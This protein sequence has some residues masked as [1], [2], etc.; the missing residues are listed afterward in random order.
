MKMRSIICMLGT[1]II[2]AVPTL[3]T[4]MTGREAAEALAAQCDDFYVKGGLYSRR[5]TDEEFWIMME[6][7]INK[8]FRQGDSCDLG[9]CTYWTWDDAPDLREYEVPLEKLERLVY[10][11]DYVD[12]WCK[13][14][15]PL[16]V[17]DG[18]DRDTAI[19]T[20]YDWI[21]AFATYDYDALTDDVLLSNE[22]SA[23][24]LLTTGKGVCASYSKLFRGMVEVVPF[25]IETGGVD[26]QSGTEYIKVAL[27]DKRSSDGASGHEWNAI[28]SSD[29]TWYCYDVTAADTS[30]N[31]N[32]YYKITTDMLF[33]E[34]PIA[35]EQPS[36]WRWFY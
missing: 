25:N 17:S 30:N 27:V 26:W 16:I 20:I 22:Q 33:E 15:V 31:A 6:A 29:G 19:R 5:M 3:A 34:Q 12:G 35:S 7:A 4:P 28:Q 21:I 14:N 24:S 10:E 23:Y 13:E 1:T 8:A 2:L 18:M 36:E 9:T 32:G 11:Q